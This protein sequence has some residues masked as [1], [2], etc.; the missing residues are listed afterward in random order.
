MRDQDKT[1]QQLIDELVALRRQVQNHRLIHGQPSGSEP[2]PEQ[3]LEEH[4]ERRAVALMGAK[5]QLEIQCAERTAALIGYSDQVVMEVVGRHH[6]EQALQTANSQLKEVLEAKT[7]L[8]RHF[9]ERTE[10]LIGSSDQLVAEVVSRHHAEQALL[11]TRDQLQ[12]VL[13][14]IPGIVSWIGSDLR[15]RGVNHHLAGIFGLQPEDFVD[16]DIG[17]LNSSSEFNDFVRDFF[18]SPAQ[19]D[20]REINAVVDGTTQTYLIVSQKYDRGRAAL[21]VGIDITERQ[22]A[23][24]ALKSTTDQLQTVLGAVPGIVSWIGADLHYRGVNHHLADLFGMESE[25][26]IGQ[27]IGFLNTSSEFNSFVR[28]FFDSSDQERTQEISALVNDIPRDYLIVA[29]KYDQGQAAFTIGVDITARKQAEASLQVTTGQLEAILEAVPG[30]VSWISSDLR[31][32]GVN[33]ELAETF[34]LSPEAFINKDIGFLETSS[35][36]TD[37]VRKFFASSAQDD[38][39]EISALVNN[40]LRN[41]LIVVQKYDQGQAAFAVGIDITQRK[42]AEEA[43]R[44]AEAKYRNIFENTVEGIFQTTLDG[45]YLSANPALARIYGYESPAALMA[46]LTNIQE[47]LYVDPTRRQTFVNTLQAEGSIVGFE[48]QIYRRDGDLIWVSEN[49]RVVSD[50]AGNIGYYEGT[51]EDITA[52][53]HAEEALQRANEELEER[54]EKRTAALTVSNQRLVIEVAERQRV[55]AALRTSEA[56]LRALFAAMTDIIAVFDAQGH[57]IQIVSTNSELLYSP[58]TERVG[59]SVREVLPSQQADLFIQ[60]IEQALAT[61]ST[62]G[63]EYSLPITERSLAGGEVDRRAKDPALSAL[64]NLEELW[65]S[66]KVSPISGDRVIWVARD[67]TERKRVE[68]ALAKSEQQLRN[69]NREMVKLAQNKALNRGDLDNAVREI[70]EVATYTL[71]VDQ[72]SV[73][74]LD[75][76]GAKLRCIDLFEQTVAI[77]SDGTELEAVAYPGYFEAL[78]EDRRLFMA[79][80][81]SLYALYVNTQGAV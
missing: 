52:R 65:F 16:Q 3:P 17:F 42:H 69:Q 62:V 24:E 30:I 71:G 68:E 55:E 23:E 18:I 79:A 64:D 36:F 4:V 39:R 49:A 70:T 11:A 27:H 12:T 66:A 32:L 74:L 48:S 51:V 2:F 5:T 38:F 1:R 80:S 63:L 78:E 14:A 28:K 31:Y 22:Q 9:A 41:Y 75:E 58:D 29:Q 45:Q 46:N 61:E 8:E 60:H 73:W 77:H 67:I 56:D 76:T 34:G 35:E 20:V 72:A 6:A 10:A 59:K 57:Y 81:Q 44:L 13:E 19:D 21:T 15:Y 50:A 54:V 7:R 37:F 43:L 26:F 53:K 40:E 33:R 25:D 47:Q